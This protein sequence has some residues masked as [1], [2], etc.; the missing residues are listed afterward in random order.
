MEQNKSRGTHFKLAILWLAIL[1]LVSFWLTARGSSAPVSLAVMPQVPQEGQPVVATFRLDNP[2]SQPQL[3]R[4]QLYGNGELLKEGA[5]VIAPESGK[6]YQ[7]AYEN[8]LEMGEQ[9]NFVVRTQGEGGN[10]EKAVS[11]PPYPPQVWSSFAS[12]AAFSTS[13]MS[14]MS[15]SAIAASMPGTD[16]GPNIG[17]IISLVLIALLIFLELTRPVLGGRTIAVLGRLR[18]RF[19]TVT[20]I[21]S[22]IF[23]GILYTTVV[24]ILAA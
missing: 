1:L 6:S 24:M 12:L 3:I 8:P 4:Y 5:A 16:A 23:L 9:L 17:L 20:W 2:S 13:I 19:S 7:Y 10:H 21:L 18:I 11:L 22:I 14:S 15:S